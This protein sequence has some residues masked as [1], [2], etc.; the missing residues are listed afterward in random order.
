MKAFLPRRKIL[1][2]MAALV[3]VGVLWFVLEYN[4]ARVVVE[5]RSGQ[6]IAQ[7][8]ITDGQETL[9]FEG[10]ADGADVKAMFHNRGTDP[11]VV[12]VRLADGTITKGRFGAISSGSLGER[13]RFVVLRRG[14]IKFRQD[15]KLVP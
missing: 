9:T 15:G 2:L 3:L 14:E 8:K 1:V 4:Q 12:E 10:I 7:L 13:A 11:I 6:P 5:N